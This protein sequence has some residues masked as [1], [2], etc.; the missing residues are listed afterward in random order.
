M[1]EQLEKLV[2]TNKLQK[3][4]LEGL[5]KLV[6]CGFCMHNAWGVGK[7]LSIDPVYGKITID[8]KEVKGKEMELNFAVERLQPLSKDHILARKF[9]QPEELKKMAA[10]DHL[11][12]VK[13][14]LKSFGN[15]ATA[16]KIQSVLV[17]DIIAEDWKKWWET[18]KA[19]IKRDGHIILPRHQNEPLIYTEETKTVEDR[20]MEDFYAARGLKARIAIVAEII[21]NLKEFS[22]KEGKA[23][24]I[25]EK[26]NSEIS[27]YQRTQ[28]GVAIE[29]IFIRDDLLKAVGLEPGPGYITPMDV[30]AQSPSL[31]M[32]L[33]QIPTT[34][35]RRLLDTF[36][37]AN[38]DQWKQ[39]IFDTINNVSSRL[40][41]ELAHILMEKEN[42][43]AFQKYLERL[44]DQ[45]TASSDLLY[46]VAKEYKVKRTGIFSN[47]VGYELLRSI[48]SAIERDMLNERKS[49]KLAD[50]LVDEYEFVI[51]LL[52]GAD[53]DT[54]KD[55]TRTIQYLTG[56]N[57]MDKRSLLG[58]IA[59]RFPFVIPLL[60][61]ES[62]KRES[63]LVVSWESLEKKKKEL[64]ELVKVKIPQ[65]SKDIEIARSY[66][67][68]SENHEYKA[69]KEMQKLLFK[70]KAELEKMI[71]MARATDFSNPNTEEVS[72]GTKVELVDLNNNERI[73]YSILGAWDFD[74]EKHIVSYQSPL[75]RELM[76]KK[77]GDIVEFGDD[78]H[79][80]VYRIESITA[81]VE[82]VPVN[83]NGQSVSRNENGLQHVEQ[84]PVMSDAHNDEQSQQASPPAQ[85]GVAVSQSQENKFSTPNLEGNDSRTTQ[86]MIQPVAEEDI[87]Q[88]T[89]TF[90]SSEGDA[91]V[92]S[93][94]EQKIA[95]QQES[96]AENQ[97]SL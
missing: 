48:L 46:W 81:A 4:N 2:K 18:A 63:Y 31:S 21:K 54:I 37:K 70:Q 39:V 28:P 14:V 35:H 65:N 56:F 47:I 15:K 32:M 68:L 59:K 16:A 10:T 26:L 43:E 11:G 88:T 79:K 55:I 95:E 20:L 57:D 96:V 42:V 90:P 34:K 40:V 23:L 36:K 93:S 44:I 66:G 13:L 8:F 19:E 84:Q 69:A 3:Q 22:D 30:W 38:P 83:G 67:D 9:T 85:S 74:E 33:E 52:E 73:C 61:H 12:L 72:I 1:R 24:E 41:P 7:I 94:G 51:E 89:S 75:A 50:F 29:A 82:T 58:H 5:L 78:L 60:A 64:D 97:K 6:E 77:V 87:S 45:H 71:A 92:A 91:N 49:T 62:D 17:P 53:E 27:S 25:V 86:L 76:H 80:R